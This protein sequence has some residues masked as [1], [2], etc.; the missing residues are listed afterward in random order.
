MRALTLLLAVCCAVTYVAGYTI[1]LKTYQHD[2]YHEEIKK[3]SFY[4]ISYE[5]GGNDLVDFMVTGPDGLSIKN[6]LQQN[7]A[8]FDFPE[9]LASGKYTYCFMNPT[10]SPTDKTINFHAHGVDHD[11]LM[12][13]EEKASP[14][15][16]EVI[17]LAQSIERILDHHDYMIVREEE[18]R[19]TAESTNSR[20]KWWAAVQIFLVGAACAWQIWYLKSFFEVKRVV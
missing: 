10:S 20:V 17:Q 19:D 13:I 11:E 12:P 15:E 14:L 3:D 7:S 1:T 16:K 5:V 8:N 6:I 9:H 4:T 18:H 2:C